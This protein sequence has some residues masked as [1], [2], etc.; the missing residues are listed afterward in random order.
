MEELY[1][2]IYNIREKL[3]EYV[4]DTRFTD[5][6]L[7]FLIDTA[8]AKYIKQQYN[9]IQRS[10]DDELI[11]TF[12][13]EIEEVDSSDYAILD[14]TGNTITK[15]KLK[16]PNIIELD[17]KSLLLRVS[18]IDFLE[19]PMNIVGRKKFLYA[20]SNITDTDQIFVTKYNKKIYIKSNK[21]LEN[22][23]DRISI[24]GVLEHPTDIIPFLNTI[25]DFIYPITSSLTDI[26]TSDIISTLANIKQLPTDTDNNSSDDATIIRNG[27]Q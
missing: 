27:Q 3:K 22:K 10:V 23:L 16:I 26:I 2:I 18:S 8:R 12:L 1:K 5:D 25:D 11:Q 15:T 20:G 7:I 9:R 6:Y 14:T 17:H 4:D 13:V 19:K 21:N 24:S